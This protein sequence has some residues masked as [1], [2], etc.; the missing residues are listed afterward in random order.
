MKILKA[1]IFMLEKIIGVINILLIMI[2][3][4][5]LLN[6]ILE[7]IQKEDYFS[8]LGYS[9]VNIT[10]YHEL[11]DL[12]KGDFVLIDLNKSPN[13]GSI[14]FFKDGSNMNLGKV[15]AVEEKNITILKENKEEVLEKD[16]IVGT[17]I[18]VIP[19]LGS[20]LNRLLTP[21]ILIISIMVLIFTTL[22]QKLSEKKQNQMK[23]PD[24]KK[25]NPLV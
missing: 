11:L 14:V 2:I 21:A 12:K 10:D 3:V 7:K 18:Q 16:L 8:F 13:E 6:I 25:Y 23:K 22:M 24:F 5:N 19:T 1:V 4:I 17:V 9:Y 20:I 15:K